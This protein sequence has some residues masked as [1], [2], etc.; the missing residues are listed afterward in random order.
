[1]PRLAAALLAL[2]PSPL[3]ARSPRRPSLRQHALVA[4]DANLCVSQT[5]KSGVRPYS[6][7]VDTIY[8]AGTRH[9]GR[10]LESV[11]FARTQGEKP[12]AGINCLAATTSRIS[13][14]VDPAAFALVVLGASAS[15]RCSCSVSSAGPWASTRST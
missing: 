12:C 1:M 11:G 6:A 3:P 9:G 8:G 15:A 14:R 5:D 2:P 13:A 4:P 10:R 7:T